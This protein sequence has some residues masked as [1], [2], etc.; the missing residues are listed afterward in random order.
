MSHYVLI[1][2]REEAEHLSEELMTAPGATAL[3]TETFGVNVGSESSVGTGGVLLAS[4]YNTKWRRPRVIDQMAIHGMREWLFSLRPKILANAKFDQHMLANENLP[5]NGVFFDTI[6]ADSLLDE[7]RTHWHGLKETTFDYLGY[8]LNTLINEE[9]N[10]HLL[11]QKKYDI[12]CRYAGEDALATYAVAVY[13]ENK[14]RQQPWRAGKSLYDFFVNYLMQFQ[15]VL[16]KMERRGIRTSEEHLSEASIKMQQKISWLE[17]KIFNIAGKKFNLN[18][19]PQKAELLYE[20]FKERKVIFTPTKKCAIC[21]KMATKKTGYIC[22][23]HGDQHLIQVPSVD[24]KALQRM[25]HPVAKLILERQALVTLRNYIE[26]YRE[27]TKPWGRVHTSFKVYGAVTGRL[28]SQC[29]NL[30]NVPAQEEEWGVR[31]G[32]IAKPGYKIIAAD[33]D[34]LE[35]MLTAHFSQDPDLLK[36]INDGHDIHAGVTKLL[37]NMKETPEEIK[38]HHKD[39]RKIGKNLNFGIL[40]GMGP[41]RLA[42]STGRTMKQAKKLMFDYFDRFP[43]L[44]QYIKQIHGFCDRY[45]FVETLAGR[46]RRLPDIHSI[47]KGEMARAQRQALNAQIQGS[48][49]DILM[50]AMLKI[51]RDERLKELGVE[52]LVQ[53]HDEIVFEVPEEN[54][55]EA[56]SILKEILH[57]PL[58]TKLRVP[59]NADPGIGDSWKEAKI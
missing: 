26:G 54:V 5:V 9:P 57:N 32:F 29:P 58:K 52:M 22:K 24:K 13:I 53:V 6:T 48:A 15:L 46:R 19:G 40:Y 34:Q 30:Q 47:D 25:K 55:K 37:F 3:D 36:I 28:S 38:K 7:N 39:K 56:G 49:S 42:E 14:L 50:A 1:K 10:T 35:Y 51:D 8:K 27:Q 2:T 33:Y 45:G 59:L 12:F 18:S 4:V 11:Y 16:W 31:A 43:I 44:R 17:A 23:D 41:M 20:K 21:G